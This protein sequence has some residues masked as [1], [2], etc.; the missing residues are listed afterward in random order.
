MIGSP[1]LTAVVGVVVKSV[2]EVMRRKTDFRVVGDHFWNR[3][4]TTFRVLGSDCEVKSTSSTDS[5]LSERNGRGSTH[6][7]KESSY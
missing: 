6:W 1:L 7:T 3:Y 2:G 5:T 4:L